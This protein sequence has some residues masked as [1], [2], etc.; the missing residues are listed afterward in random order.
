MFRIKKNITY[1]PCDVSTLL[2]INF[3]ILNFEMRKFITEPLSPCHGPWVRTFP[4]QF[5]LVSFI[6]D[7]VD[8]PSRIF[9]IL[10]FITETSVCCSCCSQH[11]GPCTINRRHNKRKTGNIDLYKNIRMFFLRFSSEVPTQIIC[12]LLFHLFI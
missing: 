8:F 9:N 7:D 6:E 12:Y 10:W 11:F 3:V 5:F 4:D 1:N 2:C